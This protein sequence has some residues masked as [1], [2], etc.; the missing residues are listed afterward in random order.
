MLRPV[1]SDDLKPHLVFE[2]GIATRVVDPHSA[3]FG[4]AEPVPRR[5]VLGC[6]IGGTF[7]DFVLY[8]AAARTFSIEKLLTTPH[9][10]GAAVIA[11]ADRLA[12]NATTFLADAERVV[13]GTTLGINALIERKGAPTAMLVTAGFRDVLELRWGNRG[14]LWDLS[15]TLPEPLIARS[16]RLEVNERL[17]SSGAV[18]VPL[19]AGQV[20]RALDACV[21]AGVTSVAVCLLHAYQNPVHERAIRDTALIRHPRLS[22]TLSSD[23]LPQLGEFE[24]FSATAANAYLRPVMARYLPQLEGQLRDRDMRDGGLRLLSSE[25]SQCSTTVAM[26][27]PIR[28]VESGP[29]GGVLAAQH[30][31]RLAGT[32]EVFTLDI[33]GT[34]AKTCLLVGGQLPIAEEY[35]VAR[36]YRLQPGSGIPLNVPSVDLLEIGAGGGSIASI[37]P[38]GML[39]I[40]PESAG[41]DPGPACYATGGT[42]PTLTDADVVLGLLD[43][44]SFK[45]IA[46]PIEAERAAAAIWE[47]VAAPLGRTVAEGALLI[48]H[49]ALEKMAS[50]IRLQLAHVGADPRGLTMVAFGGAGPLYAVDLA[51]RIGIGTVVIPPMAAVLSA[52]G[53]VMAPA[54]YTATRSL[55]VPIAEISPTTL[56]RAYLDL[57]DVATDAVRSGAASERS[58]V[59][60]ILRQAEL[61]YRGQGR[62]LRV[63]APSACSAAS[64]VEM[65]DAFHFEYDRRFGSAPRDLAIQL[66]AIRATAIVP[67]VD[68]LA[69]PAPREIGQGPD[70]L[71]SRRVMTGTV[72]ETTCIVVERGALRSGEVGSGPALVEESGSTTFVSE[73]ARFFADRSGN[74]VIEL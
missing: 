4:E 11:G 53:M 13:H 49:V 52:L 6:D 43:P 39:E 70:L 2:E 69:A 41:A 25:G 32:G 1:R 68:V 34:T 47:R 44:A 59:I 74:L 22:I 45:A 56:E 33:G 62:S 54:A 26:E 14:E 35:E 3:C 21:A 9:D 73:P 61:R 66:T 27:Y 5:F 46:R 12:S 30:F 31:G 50:A 48:R 63:A 15:G 23:V 72:D 20:A 57:A 40:G 51:R 19:D 67:S 65:V 55:V 17:D 42:L 58:S 60:T 10:P 7:T 28:V 36:A 18:L 24:R 71:R 8:D 29:V 64:V 38:L 16:L 37:G